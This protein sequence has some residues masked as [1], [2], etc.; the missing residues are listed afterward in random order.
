MSRAARFA[1]SCSTLL[2]P[3]SADVTRSSRSAHAS[4]SCASDCPRRAAISFSAR[5]SCDRFSAQHR[6]RQGF[7]L[8]R[9][10]VGRYPVE[11]LV[12]QHPLRE[13][14]EDDAADAELA[15][16]VQKT[17]LDPAV[18]HGVRRLMDEERRAEV[19]QDPVRLLRLGGGVRRDAGVERFALP[20]GC[21][22]RAHRLLERRVGIE[23]VRVEDVDVVEPHAR[24]ALVEA[25]EQILARPPLSVRAFPHVVAGLRRDHELVA[26]GPQ[27]LAEQVAEVLFRRSVRRAVVVREIEMGDTEVERAADDCATRSPAAGRNRSSA[28]GRGRSRAAADRSFRSGGTASARSDRRRRRTRGKQ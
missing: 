17:A 21:V 20:H 13:R 22:E 16:R 25:R 26:V 6:L 24:E 18:Q 3:T 19:A 11:I 12:G 28:R 15:E 5:I 10:R 1:S 23:A 7:V 2:A 9:A 14:R 27:V 4:A 8:R